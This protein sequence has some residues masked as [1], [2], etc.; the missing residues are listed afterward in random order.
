MS[1]KSLTNMYMSTLCLEMS[2]L[3]HSGITINNGVMMMLDDERDKGGK[4]VLQKLFEELENG[5]PLSTALRKAEYFPPYMM[6]MVEIGEKT[7]RLTETLKALSEHYERQDRLATAIKNAILYPAVLLAMMIV[8]VLILIVQVLPIFNDVFARLGAQM[9]PLAIQLMQF[10]TWF[11]GVSVVVALIVFAMFVIAFLSWAIPSVR[12]GLVKLFRNR[13]GNS[14][15]FGRAANS[16][17]VASMSLAMSSGLSIDDSINMAASLNSSSTVINAKYEKCS[18]LVKSGS[19]LSDALR[20]SEILSARDSRML[21]LGGRSG[22]ADVAMSEIAR[23]SDNSV[24]D[25]ISRIVSRIEPTLV[26]ITSVI[27]G[28]IL[29]SVMLPLMGIMTS[30]G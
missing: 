15:V 1:N 24:Q 23:R 8:V 27:V 19:T 12:N 30:I 21:S 13:W 7:G 14:G 4:L 2:M 6:N 17:F 5:V 20:D 29:L 3:L 28:V 11:R 26:I 22:M 10:G 9:S 18:D 16:Q 25:E